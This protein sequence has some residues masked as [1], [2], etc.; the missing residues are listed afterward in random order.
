MRR[1][2]K[3]ATS[4]LKSIIAWRGREKEARTIQ[5]GG[6]ERKG[7]TYTMKTY[8]CVTSAVDD[9]G[10]MTAAVTESVEAEQRPKNTCTSTRRKDIYKDWF[11]SRK[12]AE[13]FVDE[14]RSA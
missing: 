1:L 8:Y 6:A 7:E 14:A 11:E 4:F 13:E 10:R 9:H 12:E 5:R 3:K 2:F